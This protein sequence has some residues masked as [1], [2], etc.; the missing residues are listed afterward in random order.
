MLSK[1]TSLRLF[2]AVFRVGVTLAVMTALKIAQS[3]R[4]AYP[5]LNRLTKSGFY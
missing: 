5:R 3:I 1:E 4:I 2:C